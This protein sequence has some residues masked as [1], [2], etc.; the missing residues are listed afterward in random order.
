VKTEASI[1]EAME[2]LMKGRTSLMIAHRLTT[3]RH[4]NVIVEIADGRVMPVSSPI[5]SAFQA[6]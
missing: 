1:M 4:C 3:L 2:D 5:G 6:S